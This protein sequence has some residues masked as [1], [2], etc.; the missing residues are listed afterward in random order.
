MAENMWVRR[1]KQ[2]RDN[3]GHRQATGEEGHTSAADM[4]GFWGQRAELMEEEEAI[5][6]RLK[7][8]ED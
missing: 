1:V 5:W 2:G 7:G 8:G 6:R 3:E 4:S